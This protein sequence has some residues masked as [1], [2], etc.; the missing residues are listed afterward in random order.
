MRQRTY[1]CAASSAT[2]L[3]RLR[4]N[5]EPKPEL[6]VPIDVE[7]FGEVSAD[8]DDASADRGAALV[9]SASP[10]MMSGAGR[11]LPGVEICNAEPSAR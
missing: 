3:S 7:P 4:P 1:S 5:T 10:L 8:A 6:G 9:A 11:T 2:L